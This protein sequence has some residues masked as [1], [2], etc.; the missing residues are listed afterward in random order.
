MAIPPASHTP[1]R[2]A[3]SRLASLRAP[4][5]AMDLG[6]NSFHLL[7]ADVIGGRP[8]VMARRGVKVQLAAGLDADGNL[9]EAAMQ[10]GLNCLQEFAG[11]LEQ[12]DGPRLRIVGTNAL[13]EASNRQVFL[14]RAETLLNH[15][16]EVI[17]GREE[18]RLIYLG[19]ARARAVRGR[20]LL[21]D[22]GGGS[23]EMSLGKRMTPQNLESLAMGC[24]TYSR[25]FFADGV[26]AEAQMQAAEQAALE[27]LAAA[28][29]PYRQAGWHEA[30]GTSGTVK[31]IARVLRA[32]GDTREKGLITRSGLERLRTRILGYPHID[33]LALKGLKA[34]RAGIFPAGVAIVR[35]I[36]DA[37]GLDKL[38]FVDGALREGMLYDMLSAL[39]AQTASQRPG[40]AAQRAP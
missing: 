1:P 6:S 31:A 18:A 3:S 32:S 7:V 4:L 24:V 29:G 22:V 36:F 39:P 35:A 20:R 33:A 37:L 2:P 9:N 12:I 30:V 15:P 28:R 40:K 34:N 8:R 26:L 17:S 19:A 38:R 16:V 27:Q 14:A 10:R 25:R 23:T 11:L 13:R 21:I 5:A